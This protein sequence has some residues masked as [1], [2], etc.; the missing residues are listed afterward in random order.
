MRWSAERRCKMHM[1]NNLKYSVYNIVRW[2][3]LFWINVLRQKVKTSK[4]MQIILWLSRTPPNSTH[5]KLF[6]HRSHK[7]DTIQHIWICDLN[8]KLHD[9]W[10]TIVMVY[11]NIVVLDQCCCAKNIVTCLWKF[12]FKFDETAWGIKEQ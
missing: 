5:G 12:F 2:T 11:I 7:E 9:F 6:L 10:E 4:A 8:G 1:Q 3:K